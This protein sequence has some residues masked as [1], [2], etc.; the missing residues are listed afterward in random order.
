MREAYE[1]LGASQVSKIEKC[2][3]SY[4]DVDLVIQELDA[5][6]K[7]YEEHVRADLGFVLSAEDLA[8]VRS[9]RRLLDAIHRNGGTTA[10]VKAG[11]KQARAAAAAALAAQSAGGDGDEDDGGGALGGD[12]G[13]AASLK[14][15]PKKRK[16][17]DV[18][19]SRVGAQSSTA[20][21]WCVCTF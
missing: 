21:E 19:L 12:Q 15:G 20:E 9:N 17:A 1:S 7:V 18:D 11:G 8:H 13:D 3:Q 14:R 2:Q 4:D 6:L 5:S 16:N 10:H